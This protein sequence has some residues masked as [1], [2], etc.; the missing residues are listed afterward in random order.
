MD[1]FLLDL[2]GR[3]ANQEAK[4]QAKIL[5]KEYEKSL[6]NIYQQFKIRGKPFF[7]KIVDV[8]FHDKAGCKNTIRIF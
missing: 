4:R 6:N 5:L 8:E 7:F 2:F 3:D 1:Q